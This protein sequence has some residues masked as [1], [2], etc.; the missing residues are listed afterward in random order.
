MIILI[1]GKIKSFIAKGLPPVVLPSVLGSRITGDVSVTVT[2]I[3]GSDADV[4]IIAASSRQRFTSYF[5][6][7]ATV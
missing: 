2:V 1:I 5:S 6:S 7:G 4:T 3:F